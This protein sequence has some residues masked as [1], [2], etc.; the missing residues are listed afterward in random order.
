M[1]N[2]MKISYHTNETTRNFGDRVITV[3]NLTPENTKP[4]ELKSRISSELFE[5]YRK[6]P[7]SSKKA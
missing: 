1:P 4:D 6:Y 2:N 7:V 3:E 5:I